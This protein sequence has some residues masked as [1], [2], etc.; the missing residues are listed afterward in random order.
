ML[1]PKCQVEMSEGIAMGQTVNK[2]R[3]GQKLYTQY[4]C[5]PGFLKTCLK[6]HECGYS[7][8]AVFEGEK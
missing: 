1:C 7:K 3:P 4:Y 6:C 5:G 2:G 8:D